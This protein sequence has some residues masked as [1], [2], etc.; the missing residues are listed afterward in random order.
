[1][2]LH[3]ER[4]KLSSQG[5]NWQSKISV[6]RTAPPIPRTAGWIA[7]GSFIM[8]SVKMDLPMCRAIPASNMSGCAK[9]EI[10]T[11]SWVVMRI[12]SNSMRSS[13][14]ICS[15]GVA[16]TKLIAIRLSR[17]RWFIWGAKSE[18]RSRS[19]WEPVTVALTTA[20]SVLALA[21]SISSCHRRKTATTPNWV[22]FLSATEEFPAWVR[23]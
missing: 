16:P 18:R 23:I 15:S 12:H 14:A 13:Q 11:R 7:P 2:I 10:S 20:N 1:M 6:T 5:S 3:R 19:W 22:R 21:F 4:A 17:I 9:R 8:F